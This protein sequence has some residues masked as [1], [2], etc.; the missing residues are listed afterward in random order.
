MITAA[1]L[2]LLTAVVLLAIIINP[3]SPEM[4]FT[5]ASNLPPVL[6]MGSFLGLRH[7]GNSIF[8]YLLFSVSLLLSLMGLG[9]GATLTLV[10]KRRGT[11]VGKLVVLTIWASAPI[12]YLIVRKAMAG[13]S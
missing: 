5:F 4:S 6:F 11:A 9:F 8:L 7:N 13:F 2:V 10:R 1:G 3:R 12:L